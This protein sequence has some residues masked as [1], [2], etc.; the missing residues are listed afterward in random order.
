MLMCP[1]CGRIF[2][3]KSAY[4]NNCGWMFENDIT[5]LAD[6][7]CVTADDI[8]AYDLRVY[9]ARINYHN[10]IN[11]NM[12]AVFAKKLNDSQLNNAQNDLIAE[13]FNSVSPMLGD[14]LLKRLSDEKKRSFLAENGDRY[15]SIKN[16]IKMM[17]KK[18]KTLS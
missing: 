3:D 10:H 15:I 2:T 5:A 13:I 16:E 11:D 18:P 7:L 14:F 8:R 12:I 1:I 4:C 17:K 9:E 6:P